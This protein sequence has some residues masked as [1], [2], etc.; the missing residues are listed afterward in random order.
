[1]N[2]LGVAHELG[3]G[4]HSWVGAGAASEHRAAGWAA[5]TMAEGEIGM[6][7]TEAEPPNP[8][9]KSEG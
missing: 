9:Q 7:E 2:F 4:S 8:A 3:P 5:N 1:M 6:G